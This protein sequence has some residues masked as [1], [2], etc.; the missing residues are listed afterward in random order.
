VP[1]DGGDITLTSAG[2]TLRLQS[3]IR[4]R[5]CMREQRGRIMARGSC[6]NGWLGLLNA[7][8][9]KAMAI[10][11]G[12]HVELIADVVDVPNLINSRWG[13]NR[14]VTTG[15]SV[16]LLKLVGWDDTHDRGRYRLPSRLPASG[17]IDDATSRWRVQ[18]G[19]RYDF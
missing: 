13:R 3:F 15:P 19:A 2:D 9:T 1:R 6:R 10:A 11:S 5:S 8:L 14:D 7:R 17:L 16:T 4:D 18:L 12:Q